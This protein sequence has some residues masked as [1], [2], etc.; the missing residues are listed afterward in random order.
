[1][2]KPSLV[3]LK[4]IIATAV[5]GVLLLLATVFLSSFV[6][7]PPT[8]AEFD[9]LKTDILVTQKRIDEK[10][11]NIENTQETILTHLLERKAGNGYQKRSP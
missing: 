10:L 6:S 9:S 1:M 5:G 4:T 8:R 11:G 7:S 2:K 3:D